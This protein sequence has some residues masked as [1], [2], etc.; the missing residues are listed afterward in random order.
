VKNAA[1]I[2]DFIKDVTP[3]EVVMEMCDERFDEEIR[4]IITHPNYDKVINKV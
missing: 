4:D 2:R 3:E 1:L